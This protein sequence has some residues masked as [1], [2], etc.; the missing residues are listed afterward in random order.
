M[1]E[2][3]TKSNKE[4][5]C[6][7]FP[8]LGKLPIKGGWGRS[9]EDAVI[10]DKNDSD[11]NKMQPFNGVSIEHTI[12]QYFNYLHLITFRPPDDRYSGIEYKVIEQNLIEDYKTEKMYDKILIEIT[13]FSDKDW[14]E[15]KSEW[16][17][18]YYNPDF[19]QEEHQKKRNS[20]I[21]YLEKEYWFEISSF[22]GDYT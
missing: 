18:N 5:M 17:N 16:E 3:D 22:F 12:M 21:Q 11:V 13:C 6:E 9:K 19:N 1:S 15:L 4:L 10:I 7:I 20:K 2:I 8:T 14:D